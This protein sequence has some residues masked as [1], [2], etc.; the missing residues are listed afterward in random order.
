[1]YVL[2]TTR[3]QLAPWWTVVYVV[4]YKQV[5]TAMIRYPSSTDAE[6]KKGSKVEVRIDR[7]G[8]GHL[9]RADVLQFFKE[10]DFLEGNGFT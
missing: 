7:A 4:C 5:S 3:A 2:M 6:I 10:N 1:M 9:T 8:K